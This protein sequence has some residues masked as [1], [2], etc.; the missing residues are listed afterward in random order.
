M[1]IWAGLAISVGPNLTASLD[2]WLGGTKV[3]KSIGKSRDLCSTGHVG[4]PYGSSS[5]NALWC[6][7]TKVGKSRDMCPT[8]RVGEHWDSSP[9][10]VLWRVNRPG[11][12]SVRVGKSRDLCLVVVSQKVKGLDFC[13]REG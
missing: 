12:A 7:G 10:N 2:I 5:T 3:G 6:G 1:A 9:T 11:L 8:G 4:E 13:W